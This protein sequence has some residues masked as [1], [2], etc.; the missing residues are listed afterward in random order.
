MQRNIGCDYL[1]TNATD[2]IGRTFKI[3]INPSDEDIKMI[4]AINDND[5]RGIIFPDGKRTYLW[6]ATLRHKDIEKVIDISHKHYI[7]IHEGQ[8]FHLDDSENGWGWDFDYG[9]RFDLDGAKRY[10]N[11]FENYLRRF[12]D[13][14]NLPLYLWGIEG[15][16]KG[17][18]EFTYEELFN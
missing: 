1:E 15:L 9:Q 4:K 8:R 6:D 13:I 12:G 18:F 3:Y 11:H 2:E 7:N 16:G 10:I 5:I 17:P 14:E